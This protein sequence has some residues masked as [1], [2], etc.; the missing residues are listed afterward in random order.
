MILITGATG[1]L[2]SKT[3]DFLIAKGQDPKTIGALVRQPEKA[4]DLISK[5]VQIIQ[6]DYNN[7]ESLVDAFGKADKLL[8]VSS[9]DIAHRNTQHEQVVNAAKEAGVGHVIYTSFER[10]NDTDSSPIAFINDTHQKTEAWLKAS[11]LPTTIL[12]NNLYA[13]N[14]P[15]FLGEQVIASGSI[16]LPGGDGKTAWTLRDDMAEATAEVL[17]GEGHENKTYQLSH[18]EAHDY[19]AIASMLSEITGKEIQYTSP[20]IEAFTE[21]MTSHQVPADIIGMLVGFAQAGE[22]GEFRPKN[23]D[24]PDLLGRAPQALKDYLKQVYSK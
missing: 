3:I 7:Y 18:T 20:S 24:L 4:E 2:G 22:Q 1:N 6:G 17:V 23:T 8:F 15:M 21:T 11:G 9:S 16:Y 19:E 14:L 13:D 5:G 12:R 10:A